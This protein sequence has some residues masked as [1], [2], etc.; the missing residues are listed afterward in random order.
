MKF[1]SKEDI[2]APIGAVFEM[3]TD[4]EAFETAARRRGVE[5]RRTGNLRNH[6]PGITWDAAF[7]FRGRRRD[8][9]LTLATFDPPTHLS[10]AGLSKGMTSVFNVELMELS[11]ERTRLAVELDMKPRTIAARLLIQSLRLAKDKLTKRFK[12]RVAEAA[13]EL[14]ERYKRV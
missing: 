9:T 4:F 7:P 6:G 3:V 2:D 1:S 12:L 5:V 8:F 11:P 14:E 13:K 10:V